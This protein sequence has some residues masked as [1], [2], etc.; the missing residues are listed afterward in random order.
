M[1]AQKKIWITEQLNFQGEVNNGN[2]KIN[3]CSPE[4]IANIEDA[5]ESLGGALT[6]DGNCSGINISNKG[7][8]YYDAPNYDTDYANK[9]ITDAAINALGNMGVSNNLHVCGNIT[10]GNKH[11]SN[12][13]FNEDMDD[14]NESGLFASNVVGTM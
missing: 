7:E 4:A 14:C 8:D 11:V 9:K 3:N 13:P 5:Y 6:D 10:L 1:L 2:V 12:F